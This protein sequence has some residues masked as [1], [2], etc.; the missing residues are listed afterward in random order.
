MNSTECDPSCLEEMANK[1][2]Q[3]DILIKEIID[4]YGLGN[5]DRNRSREKLTDSFTAKTIDRETNTSNIT[6]WA[7]CFQALK[8]RKYF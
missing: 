2:T 4:I 7:N 8:K 1:H 6:L 5:K 3:N